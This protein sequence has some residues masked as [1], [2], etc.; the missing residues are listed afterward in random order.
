MIVE[1]MI[2][3]FLIA[4]VVSA[5]TIWLIFQINDELEWDD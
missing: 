4:A 2:I 5:F 1:A 3:S